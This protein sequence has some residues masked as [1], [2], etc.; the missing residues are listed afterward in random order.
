PEC[1]PHL[2]DKTSLYDLC[3]E[4]E[5]PTPP[6]VPRLIPDNLESQLSG[7]RFPLVLKL[8]TSNNSIGREYCN[9][10][11]EFKERFQLLHARESHRGAAPPF[12]QQRIDGESVYT[13][14][15]C[16]EGRKLGEVIYRPLR[17]FPENGGTSSHR[18]SIEHP[19]IAELTERLAAATRWSG[20][21]GLDFVV[22]RNDGTPL[23]IDANP[24]ANPGV[25][26]GYLAGIDWTGLLMNAVRGEHPVRATARPGVRNC[27]PLLDA[28]WIL[29][30]LHPSRNWAKNLSSR[31]RKVF[32][33][34]WT[35]DSG[36]D[37]LGR[38]EWLCHLAIGWQGASAISMSLLTGQ[39]LR[40]RFL[41]SAN[42]DPL[43]VLPMRQSLE[44]LL[45][46]SAKSH[47]TSRR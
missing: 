42:Y 39:S 21:L 44:R 8:P 33:P 4:L 25:H 11:P 18:E 1:A 19:K 47:R 23:L 37:F 3:C 38:S 9:T 41:E 40:Q 45:V 31:I 36:H 7:L 6:T 17:C 46:D 15:L 27:T 35:L 29:D 14:M 16:H 22:D 13:L 24:R 2:H 5:I 20:F 28:M 10:M 43:T 32:R 30:G 26:L 34:D 12:V